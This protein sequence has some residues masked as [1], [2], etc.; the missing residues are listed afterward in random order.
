M[1]FLKFFLPNVPFPGKDPG[2]DIIKL[3]AG[4]YG[5]DASNFK[6][7]RNYTAAVYQADDDKIL[8]LTNAGQ[9]SFEVIRQIVTWQNYLYSTTGSVAAVIPS[10][11]GCLAERIRL[12]GIDYTCVVYQKLKGEQLNRDSWAAEIFEKTGHMTG[13]LHNMSANYPL[14]SEQD[15]INDWHG[16]YHHLIRHHIRD[17][18]RTIWNR[19]KRIS[20][21]VTTHPRTPE[22]YGIIHNDIHRGNLFLDQGNLYLFDFDETCH[23]WYISDISNIIYNA[24]V[25]SGK[26]FI[27]AG[28]HIREFCTAFWKGYHTAYRLSDHELSALP[29]WMALRAIHAYAASLG[30][31]YE[32]TNDP[33][34]KLYYQL[35]KINAETQIELLD[36]EMFL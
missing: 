4:S 22:C 34:K 18:S 35:N 2:Q 11:S 32:K 3:A 13:R 28:D 1:R 8:K 24:V 6:I 36:P 29:S 17:R 25:M 12:N 20:E 19:Y 16:L 7:L 30:Y 15:Q 33:S 21:K 23:S 10:L 5:L 27:D 26:P 9:Q 14:Q 31:G